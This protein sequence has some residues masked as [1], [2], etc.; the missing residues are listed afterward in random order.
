M[1]VN[2]VK[3]STEGNL[4][5]AKS[6]IKKKRREDFRFGP[7]LGE[8]SYST[9]VLACEKNTGKE[10]A[11]KILEK[12]HIVKEKKVPQVCLYFITAFQFVAY[13]ANFATH[14]FFPTSKDTYTGRPTCLKHI[15]LDI[16]ENKKN[17]LV[18]RF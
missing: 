10:Y 16:P 17:R 1:S 15:N 5:P 14:T 6:P 4:S 8:G 9:V 13:K 11:M 7:T 2:S 12:R 18:H 3:T